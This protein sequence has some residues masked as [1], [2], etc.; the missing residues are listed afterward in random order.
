MPD[1]HH[2]V[3]RAGGHEQ[4]L[5]LAADAAVDE[6]HEND[7]AAVVVVLTVEDQR[8]ERRVRIAGGRGHA[9]HDRF[10]DRVDIDARLGRDLRRVLRR[11]ADDLLD[12]VLDALRVGGGQVDLVDDGQDLQIVVQREVGVRER[13]G[14]HALARVDDQ[15][16]SLAGGERAADL[17]VEVDV[18]RRVDQIQRIALAV[19]RL[20]L[21]PYGAGLDRDAALLFQLHVVEDLVLH[22]TLLHRAAFFDQPVGERGLAVVDV[23]DDGEIAD[24][25]LVNHAR[26]LPSSQ[27]RARRDRP[28]R[29]GCSKNPAP[30]LAPD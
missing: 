10:Q 18:P 15:H 20:V 14:L 23:G 29:A 17:V 7:D 27:A 26:C 5:L 3:A 28:A 11:N 24:V 21:Q 4:D 13:L 8:L 9:R 30:S 16:G 25:P 6:A 19:L 22:D 1:L 2:L 12:L